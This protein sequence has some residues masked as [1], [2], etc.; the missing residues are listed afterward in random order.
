MRVI[1]PCALLF[2]FFWTSS[3]EKECGG[4]PA[5]VIF[6][7]DSSA[8]IYADDFRRQIQF[9]RDV[10]SLFDIGPEKTRVGVVL[11]STDVYPVFGLTQFAD[12]PAVEQAIEGIIQHVGGTQT[13]KALKHIRE[14]EFKK[15]ARPKV[16][17]IAIVL[18]DG[19]SYDRNATVHEAILNHE[20][21]ITTFVIGIGLGV[22]MTE[23]S[24]LASDP[25]SSYLHQIGN[26]SALQGIKKILAIET[27]KVKYVKPTPR[28]TPRPTIQADAPVD[29]SECTLSLIIGVDT[30]GVSTRYTKNILS[31]LSEVTENLSGLSGK[32]RTS[33]IMTEC[34]DSPRI[35]RSKSYAPLIKKMRYQIPKTSSRVR[36]AG[37]LFINSDIEDA[38]RAM[39]EVRRARFIGFHL[40]LVV[41]GSNRA[42]DDLSNLLGVKSSSK[43]YGGSVFKSPSY[44][45]L[46]V[47][48]SG[49]TQAL[50]ESGSCV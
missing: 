26:Y 12:K 13:Q 24:D 50:A 20:A 35:V 14:R 33:Q 32:V 41:V 31:F 1:I 39:S 23:L 42:E 27:C 21:G 16:P 47:I 19:Q 25:S 29:A 5:D 43:E 4:K 34:A 38:S 49:L 6:V 3:A 15:N 10:V 9:T 18:T 48:V 46:P 40:F 28:P 22:D 44:S 17:Q 37:I 45:K 8:S 7:L 11:F 30:N 2:A 36:S